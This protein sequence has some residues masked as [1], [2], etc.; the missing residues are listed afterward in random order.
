MDYPPVKTRPICIIFS[1]GSVEL[2]VPSQASECAFTPYTIPDNVDIAY[3]IEPGELFIGDEEAIGDF[4]MNLLARQTILEP[5]FLW[6]SP[7]D[8]KQSVSKYVYYKGSRVETP[9]Q[10]KGYS[11]FERTK[12]ARGGSVV[13][14]LE[15]GFI[16]NDSVNRV[17]IYIHFPGSTSVDFISPKEFA[18]GDGLKSSLAD[19][20]PYLQ[21]FA[22][23]SPTGPYNFKDGFNI[24]LLN[25][26][27]PHT[28]RPNKG[29]LKG[30]LLPSLLYK[31]PALAKGCQE[32]EELWYAAA[33]NYM[34]YD[35]YDQ[36]L[37]TEEYP[38][39]EFPVF[40][41]QHHAE[42]FG[43]LPSSLSPAAEELLYHVNEN[44]TVNNLLAA[45]AAELNISPLLD[46]FAARNAYV[47]AK[48]AK[49]KYPHTYRKYGEQ[50][51]IEY[52]AIYPRPA[53]PHVKF[54]KNREVAM[55]ANRNRKTKHNKRK[56]RENKF[57]SKK[58]GEKTRRLTKR[59]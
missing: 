54:V 52:E 38:T 41:K 2:K 28:M 43:Y 13:D 49:Y 22:Y 20:I 42:E 16:G 3:F 12:R 55:K 29:G 7:S 1:H 4:S 51:A 57:F 17:G 58:S 31:E 25:C 59:S 36:R 47:A 48:L 9:F 8:V 53:L 24:V 23:P 18:E 56:A 39:L 33:M 14:N 46:W 45:K 44:V 37:L 11:L 50:K 21:G 35:L 40:A 5:A 19:I 26:H 32:I 30:R 6:H 15:F 27:S 34:A 10:Q